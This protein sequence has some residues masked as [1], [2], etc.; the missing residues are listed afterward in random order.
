VASVY[1]LSWVA[2]TFRGKYPHFAKRDAPV[3]TRFLDLYGDRWAAFA[4]DVALGGATLPDVGVKDAERLGWQYA[5][6]L[7]VDA[8]GQAVDAVWMFEVRPEATV[9]ALGSALAYA[10]VAERDRV[11]PF[12][13]VSAVVCESMQGDVHWCCDRLGVVVFTV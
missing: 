10:L 5:T 11:F 13:L 7:K 6:A 8:C 1:P 3:W 9:S 2:N 12:P 4:Y